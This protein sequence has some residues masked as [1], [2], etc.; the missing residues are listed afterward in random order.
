MSSASDNQKVSEQH[1]DLSEGSSPEGSYCEGIRSSPELPRASA[2]TRKKRNSDDEV[3]D[4]V[5][6]EAT[7]KKKAV[8]DQVPR[9]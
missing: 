7:S 9:I 2:K 5:A 4:F 1:E 3:D 8:P 6:S